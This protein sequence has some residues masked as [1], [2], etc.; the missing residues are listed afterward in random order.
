MSMI[1][2]KDPFFIQWNIDDNG[3]KVS[4][5]ILNEQRQVIGNILVLSQLPD[6]QYRVFIDETFVEIDIKEEI[7]QENQFKVDYTYGYIV[8]HPSL[9]GQTL[10]IKKYYG[11]G[12]ILTHVSRIFTKVEGDV[13]ETLASII[14]DGTDALTAYGGIVKA[15]NDAEIKKQALDGSITTGT[16]LNAELDSNILTGSQL[17]TDL[18]NDISQG[19]IVKNELEQAIINGDID[20][21]NNNIID[22]AGIGRT[23]E[24]VKGN[25]DKIGILED[26]YKQPEYAPNIEATASLIPLS[27]EAV[28]GNTNV[29]L[30]GNTIVNS[31]KGDLS[32][33]ISVW[34]SISASLSISN[35]IMSITGNG[36]GQY[37]SA[38]RL[39]TISAVYGKKIFV[40][41]RLKPNA[42]Q[43]RVDL[44]INAGVIQAVS[45]TDLDTTKFKDYYAIFTLSTGQT[46]GNKVRVYAQ[47]TYHS[48]ALS[49]GKVMEMLGGNDGVVAIDL[50]QHPYLSGLTAEEISA[51][52]PYYIDGM[53]SSGPL[54]L[55]SVGKNLFD[56]KYKQNIAIAVSVGNE[57]EFTST[58]NARTTER[59]RCEANKTY[60]ISGA[61]R[62]VWRFENANGIKIPFTSNNLQTVVSP[63]D[64]YYM[65]VY[66][67][68]DGTHTEVQIE[69]GEISTPYEPYQ[70][71][72][73]YIDEELRSLP[74][75]VRDSVD[76]GTLFR[77]TREYILQAGDIVTNDNLTT[78]QRVY[79]SKP[80]DSYGKGNT[81]NK[82]YLLSGYSELLEGSADN[83]NN[84]GKFRSYGT[85]NNIE[86]FVPLGTYANLQAA[87][88]ALAGT[89][90]IYQLAQPEVKELNIP[91][92]T[93]FEKGTVY[94]TPKKRMVLDG[95]LDWKFRENRV[96][97]KLVNLPNS[98]F[99]NNNIKSTQINDEVKI[100]IYKPDKSLI[101]GYYQ[102]GLS[103]WEIDT[104]S[105]ITTPNGIDLSISISNTDSGW[106]DAQTPTPADIKA[107]FAKNPYI[108]I[109]EIDTSKT[110]SPTVKLLDIPKN[111]AG[112]IDSNTNAIDRQSEILNE[113]EI[114][115]QALQSITKQLIKED[116]S[117]TV[118]ISRELSLVGSQ[119]VT[120]FSNIPKYIDILSNING[121]KQM[122]IGKVTQNRNDAL[123]R[124]NNDLTYNFS[125]AIVHGTDASNIT[126]GTI[127]INNDKTITINWTK[128]SAG[129]T[130]TADI[131]I[132]AHYH[133]E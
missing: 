45:I 61:N 27:N 60:S 120:G 85:V 15:I 39:S 76:N 25:S 50:D 11:R 69:E 52:I 112:Q 4:V 75:G 6:I 106:T 34:H 114:K 74:N 10:N 81:T 73:A 26:D 117:Q 71:S 111:R 22:L 14:E 33:G 49:E 70:E 53:Q 48:A 129:G 133:G 44:M 35:N 72:V 46:E 127:T 122:C 100:R 97:F 126:R 118:V 95:S 128:D 113:Y 36:S 131:K 58:A 2:Y 83:V 123:V 92:L 68:S 103:K 7:T 16:N 107:Y 21:I 51:R 40:R 9:N 31:I 55:K 18:D 57:G 38:S 56:G 8:T 88:T 101:L 66:Y 104:F 91:M 87:Q 79:I 65:Y 47:A 119:V 96:G 110:V 98:N 77:N 132:I 130:G 115:L 32:D 93:V 62:N 78:V 99:P 41:F 90:L 28:L 37:P 80:N 1:N 23:T 59:I 67:S 116:L 84:V 42:D 121:T 30:Y 5:E 13:A 3:N 19:I 125:S 94:V 12:V 102:K 17:K 86:L 82:N 108:L 43:L 29:E 105:Y 63:P 64:A 24:T 109:Y 54:K 89:K 124:L 20:T